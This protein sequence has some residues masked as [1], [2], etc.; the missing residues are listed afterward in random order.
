MSKIKKAWLTDQGFKR[1]IMA[2]LSL[3]SEHPLDEIQRVRF[4]EM[5]FP[6][7]PTPEHPLRH[8]V[9]IDGLDDEDLRKIR[10]AIDD[11]LGP[12]ELPFPMTIID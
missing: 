5:T 6:Q 9:T 12:D 11:F 10:N 8:I 4:S 3:E 1:S 7:D 2:T